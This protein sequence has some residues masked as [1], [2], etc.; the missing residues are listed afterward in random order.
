MTDAKYMKHKYE[1]E[2]G[3]FTEEDI[4][5]KIYTRKSLEQ[6]DETEINQ[7]LEDLIQNK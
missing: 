2:W 7:M 5:R 4:L 6:M 3:E 1:P